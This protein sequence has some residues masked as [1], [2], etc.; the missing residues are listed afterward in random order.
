MT[1]TAFIH[2]IAVAIAVA[3]GTGTTDTSDHEFTGVTR[4]TD[5]RLDLVTPGDEP[6]DRA[7]ASNVSAASTPTRW[8]RAP[9]CTDWAMAGEDPHAVSVEFFGSIPACGAE[10]QV[11]ARI[12]C[13]D[14]EEIQDPLWRSD[15][16]DGSDLY[17]G[18]RRVS[19][20]TCTTDPI[21][22]LAIEA[23]QSMTIAP[24][25]YVL[26]PDNGWATTHQGFYAV[27]NAEAQTAT[28]TLTGTTVTL[29]ATPTTWHWSSTDGDKYVHTT[30][31]GG[32][33]SDDLPI[34]FTPG[35]RRIGWNLTTTWEG[36]YSLNGGS[37]WIDAPGTATT[38]S[39]QRSI[40]LYS[41]TP[42]LVDCDLG[43]NCASGQKAPTGA[44]PTL[45]DP[46][47]DGIDNH[48][49]PDD[50]INAYLDK[51]GRG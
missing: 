34:T 6:A 21:H 46:D 45:T 13:G 29:R 33:E 14:G 28:V 9:M 40:H 49:V 35:E 39:E 37:T 32:Y 19:Y 8:Q 47:A 22:A 27:P 1:A 44:V 4:D 7:G 38:T 25:G 51:V 26:Q 41:P 3:A 18:W 30:P 20:Y 16:L 2:A 31:A 42:R 24:E 43:G 15:P 23:W 36:A 5:V 11:T 10:G 12:E 48:A 17:G 50:D